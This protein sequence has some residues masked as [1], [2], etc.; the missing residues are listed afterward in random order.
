MALQEMPIDN[1]GHFMMLVPG[2]LGIGSVEL[3][4]G[5]SV[6]GFIC[7][8][9]VKEAAAAGAPNVEEITHLGSWLKYVESKKQG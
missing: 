5:S 7:E 3:D 1:F 9:W 8:G 4:D 2:P 6:K